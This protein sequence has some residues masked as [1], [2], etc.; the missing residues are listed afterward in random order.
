MIA[1]ALEVKDEQHKQEMEERLAQQREEME[2]RFAQ[3]RE[4]HRLDL[5][6]ITR[7][8]AVQMVAYDAYFR[9]LK[10]GTVVSL[11]PE[12]TT[13]RTVHDLGSLARPIVI[14]SADS[15]QDDDQNEARHLTPVGQKSR[16]L[17]TTMG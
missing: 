6:A 13:K 7:R 16:L 17:K 11:E 2:E 10:G 4:E 1:K 9:S 3:Q 14:L 5:D 8:F 12:V 15:T